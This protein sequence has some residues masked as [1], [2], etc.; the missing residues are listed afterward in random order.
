MNKTRFMSV[1]MTK[2][3]LEKAHNIAALHGFS[4]NTSGYVRH[5]LFNHGFELEEKIREIH[6]RLCANEKPEYKVKYTAMGDMV[7]LASRMES[8]TAKYNAQIVISEYTRERLDEKFNTNELEIV[9]VKGF[10]DKIKV[11]ELV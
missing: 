3:D 1:R 7:N 11:Y 6:E 5:L 10:T 9:Q 4:G 8:L 2:D